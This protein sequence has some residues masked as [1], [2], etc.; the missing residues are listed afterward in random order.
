MGG[1]HE[2]QKRGLENRLYIN[3]DGININYERIGSGKPVLLLHGWMAGIDTMR[4]IA[5]HLVKLGREA[6]MLDFPGMGI[7]EP[8]PAPWGVPEYA[9]ITRKFI[10]IL[11]LEGCDLICHSFGGRV[12]IMLASAEP[13]LFGKLILIDAAGPRPKR[14]LV[15]YLKTYSYKLAKKAAKVSVFNRMFNLDQKIKKAGSDDYKS[16]SGVMRETFVKVVNL[17]LTELLDK[18]RNET[19]LIWGSEDTSAPLWM[20]Q[21]MEKRMK[22]AGLAVI[23]GAGHFSYIDDYLRFCA[24]LDIVLKD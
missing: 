23:E 20:G 9:E 15:Y 16:L 24:M 2:I 13:D 3:I 4:P 21:L 11:G 18:I 10:S 5:A 14:S 19:L 1:T 8:P 6:V 17:D 22:N 7:S 12:T